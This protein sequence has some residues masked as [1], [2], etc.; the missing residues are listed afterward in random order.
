MNK[1][2]LIAAV[3]KQTNVSKKDAEDVINAALNT[4]ADTLAAGDSVKLVGFGKFEI[5]KYGARRG[6]SLKTHTAIEIPARN[7][8]VFKAGKS[9][10]QAAKLRY[11]A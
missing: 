4:I 11:E 6:F 5:R 2:E 10:K 9:L 3:A 1:S 7:V 8:P